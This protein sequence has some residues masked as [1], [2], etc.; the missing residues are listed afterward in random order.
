[1]MTAWIKEEFAPAGAVMPWGARTPWPNGLDP[2]IRLAHFRHLG[3]GAVIFLILFFVAGATEPAGAAGSAANVDAARIEGADQDPA[4]WMTYGGTYS[5]QR[6]SPLS[7]ITADNVGQLGLAWFADLETNRGQE[8]TPL[9]IDGVMYI[10]TAWSMVKAFDAKTG[11]LLW[12]YDPAVPREL[13]VRGCCDVVNRGVAAW[14]GKIYVGTFDGRLVVIE[15]SSIGISLFP[16]RPRR[17]GY[18]AAPCRTRSSAAS[19]PRATAVT[20]S[21][22]TCPNVVD[23]WSYSNTPCPASFSYSTTRIGA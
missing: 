6:F 10:S 4:N 14:K 1:M 8:A 23:G 9:V 21:S 18:S 13:G 16:A 15:R 17:R 22:P 11:A 12:S 7:Q 20:C 5:E 19:S 3:L 2:V